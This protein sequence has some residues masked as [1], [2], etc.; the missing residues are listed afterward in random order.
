MPTKPCAKMN[1][2]TIGEMCMT[3]THFS[4]LICD[5]HIETLFSRPNNFL[6]Y[7]LGK[8]KDGFSICVK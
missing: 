2:S 3:C 6:I 8:G 1:V 7:N 4:F 5:R